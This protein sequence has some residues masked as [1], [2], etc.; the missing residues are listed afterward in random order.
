MKVIHSTN[1]NNALEAG[2]FHLLHAGV[3]EDSRN[4]AVLV[5]PTPVVTLTSMPRQRVLFSSLRDAN[6]FFHVMEAVWMLCGRND[7]ALPARYAKQLELYSDDGTTLNGAYG[8]RWRNHFGFDQLQDIIAELTI[9]PTSRRCVLSMWDG[10]EDLQAAANGS[11]D[12]PCNTHIYFRLNQGAVDMTVS[13][14]SNDAVW[15]AHG[16]NVVHFSFLQ[17]YVAN[18]LTRAV[19]TLYQVSNNYHVYAER[20]DVKRL[21]GDDK[22]DLAYKDDNRYMQGV[23]TSAYPVISGGSLP[24]VRQAWHDLAERILNTALEGK[25]RDQYASLRPDGSIHATDPFLAKVVAPLA[26]AHEAYKAGEHVEALR[27]VSEIEAPDWKVGCAEWL[28]RRW[29]W[30]GGVL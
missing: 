12:V 26:A 4:G 9:N 20:E 5:A 14:R 30:N 27:Y 2:L 18:C 1:P 7:V 19:G 8:H 15:G 16:A 17:E 23:Y 29:N 28:Y 13:C 25:V 11:K 24:A 22:E 3:R 21:I 10:S 6:P